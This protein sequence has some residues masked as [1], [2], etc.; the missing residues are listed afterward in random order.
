LV[1][2]VKIVLGGLLLLVAVRMWRGRPAPGEQ[3]DLPKMDGRHRL[4]HAGPFRRS[5][6]L[7]SAV[8]PKNRDHGGLCAVIAAKLVG[9]GITGLTR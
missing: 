7:L 8:N 3:A 6:F 4:V 9:D 5:R 1:S 2:I